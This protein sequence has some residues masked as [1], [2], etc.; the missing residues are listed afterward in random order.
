MAPSQVS[1]VRVVR[2]G[3]DKRGFGSPDELLI[4]TKSDAHTNTSFSLPSPTE[5]TR[6]RL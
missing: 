2:S 1:L 6:H 4:Q 5:Y 3:G